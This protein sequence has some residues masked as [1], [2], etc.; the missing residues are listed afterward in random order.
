MEYLRVLQQKSKSLGNRPESE[1]TDVS[2]DEF[3]S[4]P[5]GAG[6]CPDG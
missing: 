5:A 1:Q 3:L 6:G 4:L 2:I